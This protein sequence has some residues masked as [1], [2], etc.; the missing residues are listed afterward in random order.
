M[1]QPPDEVTIEGV[2]ITPQ[3]IR[4]D[5]DSY[6]TAHIE[7][8]GVATGSSSGSQWLIAMACLIIG[9]IVPAYS[10]PNRYVGYVLMA[11][12]IFLCLYS[13]STI[14]FTVAI[15]TSG[16]EHTLMEFRASKRKPGD[17]ASARL[18]AE[19]LRNAIQS[20]L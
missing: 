20:V 19:S 2:T 6:A 17:V 7:S 15:T 11:Y 18:K 3:S 8:V 4:N 10:Y 1:S 14:T 12:A 13:S 16:R 9:A 5:S